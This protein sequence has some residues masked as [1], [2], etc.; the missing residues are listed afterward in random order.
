MMSQRHIWLNFLSADRR[1]LWRDPLLRW[2][3]LL[4]PA[5]LLA[6]R[7]LVPWA[8]NALAE[9]ITLRDW[10][11]LLVSGI[12]PLAPMLVGT[13]VG[14]LFLDQKDD[15]TLQAMAVTPVGLKGYLVYRL[16]LPMGLSL[17]FTLLLL[18]VID[19]VPYGGGEV[20]FFA[21][22]TAPMGPLFTLYLAALADNK[23][24]GFALTKATGALTMA[25]VFAWFV[26][27][28]WQFLFGIVPT[29]WVAKAY[30]VWPHSLVAAFGYGLL[31][32]I[33]Q[34][35]LVRVFYRRMNG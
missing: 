18:P 33:Y 19:L 6:L 34:G 32:M 20:L 26:P 3:L 25:P 1:Q 9:W 30:W 15:R 13:V 23:V 4:I 12:L 5:L 29:Y 22:V 21:L 17:G 35:V 11:R 16:A 10:Y 31:A 28:P 7:W 24:Q 14:F 27:E 2:I 8:D